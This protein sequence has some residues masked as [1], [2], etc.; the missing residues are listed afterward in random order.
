LS[1]EKIAQMNA[2]P[3]DKYA[4]ILQAHWTGKALKV[5]TELSVEDYQDYRTQKLLCLT[6]MLLYQRSTENASKL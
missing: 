4:A 2:F 6:N 3:E 1:F 5:F